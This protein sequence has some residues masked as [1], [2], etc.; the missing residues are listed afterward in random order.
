MN[1]TQRKTIGEI[2]AHLE[3]ERDG[4]QTELDMEQEKYDNMPESLQSGEAGEKMQAGID[5]ITS[6]VESI[7]EAIGSIEEVL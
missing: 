6:A 2:K 7:D 1:N 4:L 5:A 3:V